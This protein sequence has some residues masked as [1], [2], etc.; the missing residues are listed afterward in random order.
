MATVCLDN[1]FVS[2]YLAEAQYTAEF[3]QNFGPEDEVLLPDIVRFEALVPAFRTGSGRHGSKV[4]RALS[5]FEPAAFDSGVAQEAA[6]V[7]AELLD[8]G[9][10]MGS[11]DVLIAGTALY[12]GADIVTD[13]QAFARVDGLTVRNPKRDE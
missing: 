6:E 8:S 9:G 7:R 5:G 12:H 4:R 2:D 10:P 3:L 1:N 11:P 13:D